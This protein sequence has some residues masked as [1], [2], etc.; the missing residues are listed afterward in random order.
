MNTFFRTLPRSII[1]SFRGW[2]G[3]LYVLAVVETLVLVWWG[4]DWKYF[5]AV[6]EPA[7]NA[8]FFPAIIIGAFVPVS[9]PLYMVIAGY[10]GDA[11]RITRLGWALGQAA[12]IGSLV[13][14]C[15][16]A[17]TGRAEPD[18]SNVSVD[19]STQFNFGFFEHGIFWGWP[20]SH[21]TIAF[22]MVWTLIVLYPRSR[23][24]A[25]YAIM[26]AL[27]VGV[28]VSLSIHWL[29]EFIAGALIGTAI[30]R[31]VGNSFATRPSLK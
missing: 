5:V 22:A 18:L 11:E 9:V 25:A 8:M 21:T 12:L 28:G 17:V 10:V 14:S 6:R 3:L 23:H 30:G 1:G 19:I 20:S 16:K 15:L 7:L 27:Y 4:L 24:L 13:S 26:Y 2:H 29:S 31:S